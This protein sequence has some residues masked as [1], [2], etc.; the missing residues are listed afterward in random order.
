M[1]FPCS[2]SPLSHVAASRRLL[3]AGAFCACALAAAPARAQEFALFGGL[4]AGGG[5]RSYAWAFDY[6]EGLGRYAAA[7]F[8]W[9][10]EGH[11][12]NHHRDGQAVQLWGRLPLRE[13][14]FVISAGVGPYRYF[15]TVAATE[16]RGY[17]NSHGW[18]MLMSVRAA[19]YTSHRWLA[20]LQVNRTQVFSGPNT[21]SL[22][23]GI[24]Y[25]LDAPDTPGPRDRA[26]GRA[27]RVTANEVTAMLGET[28]L[29]SRRSPTALGGSL[30]Y[31]RGIAKYVDW[32]ATYLY[33]G[34]KQSVR[35]N[36]IASQ[37]WLTRAFLDDKI[38]LSA[39]AGAYLTLNERDIRGRPGKGDGR[40]SG[41][42][43]I[44][45]S[46]RF[47]D[48]WLARVTWN[49]VVTRYDRDTDVIQAGLGYRF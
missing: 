39:G 30:E 8:A 3:L 19:Y 15:D 24:G 32:T 12:P 25:Q 29:N 44:S 26:A 46:Y 9:Y 4:L 49:R 10:N 43:S 1:P 42:V 16:G 14:R 48:R 18:G 38:A 13:N 5:G 40:V 41:I 20:Q 36:G 37:V 11:I 23:F 28:I 47:D 35:R 2:R 33:E 6:Q 27:G 22:M 17:S 31:R 7:G 21:T 45:A 34:A